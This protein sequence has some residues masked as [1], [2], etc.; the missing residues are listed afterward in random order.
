MPA[1]ATTSPA[2]NAL[3]ERTQVLHAALDARLQLAKPGAGRAEYA[4][5][6]SAMWGWMQPLAARL[7]DDAHWP[8][9]IEPGT[10]AGKCAWLKQDLQAAAADG[11]CAPHAPPQCWH[12]MDFPNAA[13]RY[14]WAYVIEGS[15]LGGTVLHRRLGARLAPWPMRYLLGYGPEAGARWRVF[16]GALEQAVDTPARREAAAD[17]AAMAF[18]SIDAWFTECGVASSYLNSS[19]AMRFAPPSAT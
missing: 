2:L 8:A 19:H 14:G 4:T 15:M 16:L 6:I 11:F 10:R 1:A 9:A 12:A 5:Y 3:R 17:A 7:W 13:V 18:R